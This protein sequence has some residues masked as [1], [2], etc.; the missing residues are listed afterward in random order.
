MTLEEFHADLLAE[1]RGL[2]GDRAGSTPYPY[3]ESVF[4]EIVMQY[5]AGIGMTFEPRVCHLERKSGNAIMRISGY[6]VSDDALQLDL[7][8]SA[9]AN[10]DTITQIPDSGTKAM[11]DQCLRFLARSVDGKLADA[12]DPSDDAR[13]LILTIRDCYRDLEQIR[14]YV[15]TDQ[16]AK[17]RNFK[18]REVEG[19]TIKFEVMD[20]ERLYRHLSEGKAREE[21][22]VNF[23]ELSGGP[24]PCVYVPGTNEEYDYA[25]TAMPGAALRVIYEKY[26]ARLLEANVRSFLSQTGVVNKGIRDTLR[27]RPERFMAYNNGIVVIADKAQLGRTADGGVGIAAL[28]GMQIVNGGQT[29][30]SIYFTKK[31][32][33]ETDLT[34]V[35]VPTKIIVLKSATAEI[36]EG[37]VSDISKFSN[38]QNS[39]KVSDLSANKPFHV[40]LERLALTTYCP[41]GV[42]RW[43]Y[44]RAAGSYN[45]L[46]AREGTT[47]ARL[48]NLKE[49]IPAS[50]KFSKT[51]FASSQNAWDQKPQ[52]VS[53]GI[54]KNFREFTITLED[55][56]AAMPDVAFFKNAVAKIILYKTSQKLIR[57]AF[58]SAQIN[59]TNYTV[60]LIANRLGDRLSLEA[61]WQRQ[62]LSPGLIRQIQTWSQEVNDLLQQSANGRLVSEWAKKSECWDLVREHVYS[63]PS[64]D[65]AE[66]SR[67]AIPA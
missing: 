21:L 37:L 52:T 33:P 61:I 56:G 30:A 40:E 41:D 13:E 64:P 43:F 45:V 27:S 46:L 65:I 8:I 4:C 15:I 2:I 47:P 6:A 67:A 32:F 5:M 23:E 58:K 60:S 36:E 22:L 62:G 19:K 39:V 17:T 29:T 57:A 59:T 14:I 51:D 50:R 28:S 7:F 35:R 26:G 24:L 55:S 25:L 12:I 9:F 38:S 31:K 48:R 11:A 10:T 18:P 44:E 1:V 16:Q 54:Q 20:I 53:L 34:H 66:L 63:E 42:G 49:T 3:P